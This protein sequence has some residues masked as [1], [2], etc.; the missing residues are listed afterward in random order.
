V[1]ALRPLQRFASTPCCGGTLSLALVVAASLVLV[2]RVAF[3]DAET[4]W[5]DDPDYGTM[6]SSPLP[7]DV[8]GDDVLDIVMLCSDGYLYAFDGT[9]E[10]DY[11]WRV[12]IGWEGAE[13]TYGSAAAAD[14]DFDGDLEIVVGCD[15]GYVYVLDERGKE[16]PGHEEDGI[17]YTWDCRCG[18]PEDERD[19][20]I[21]CS[22]TITDIE[23]EG[24]AGH[25]IADILVAN[26]MGLFKLQLDGDP[27]PEWDPDNAP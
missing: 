13:Y 10:E 25:G 2:P 18:N 26:R 19:W 27:P 20:A 7:I 14:I 3:A 24:E 5:R 23:P 16:T 1:P 17:E 8:N 9:D 22:P 15:D 21:V 6:Y 12:A 4:P 11:V